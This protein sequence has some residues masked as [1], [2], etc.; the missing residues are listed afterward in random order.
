MAQLVA[1][2]G[3]AAQAGRKP[4]WQLANPWLTDALDAQLKEQ[5]HRCRLSTPALG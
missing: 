3:N 2:D 5:A 1:K 4:A